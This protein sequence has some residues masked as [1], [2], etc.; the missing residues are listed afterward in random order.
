MLNFPP[1]EMVSYYSDTTNGS[2][3]TVPMSCFKMH[4]HLHWT[5][6]KGCDTIRQMAVL[7]LNSCL[8][9]AAGIKPD[10]LLHF[11]N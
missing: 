8:K 4:Y 10:L 5:G 3:H 2:L 1:K 9:E 6:K 7:V 11:N